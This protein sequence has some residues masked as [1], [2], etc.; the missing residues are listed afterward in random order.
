VFTLDAIVLKKNSIKENK[1]IFYLF[2]KDFGKISVWLKE[3]KLKYPIDLG[4][5]INCVIKTKDNVN[6][7]DSYKLKK[8]V[9]YS[10]LNFESIENILDLL[11]YI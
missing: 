3:S 10:N 1:N 2:S 9:D 4:C 8:V 5:I 11:N 6:S 7:V